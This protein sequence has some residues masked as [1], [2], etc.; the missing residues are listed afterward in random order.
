MGEAAPTEDPSGDADRRQRGPAKRIA[1]DIG[2]E[3]VLAD[4][5]PAQ[6][7][8][9]VKRT[10]GHRQE[11]R[12][13]GRRRQRCTCAVQANVGFAIGAGTDVAMDSAVALMKS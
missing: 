6:K 3:T 8:A 9:K 2:I 13:G 12:D 4:V 7:A 1:A 10:S 5:L 11:G